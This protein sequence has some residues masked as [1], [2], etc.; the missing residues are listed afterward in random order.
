MLSLL[1][2]LN[3]PTIW[4]PIHI[5]M[6]NFLGKIEELNGK[7]WQKFSFFCHKCARTW[8]IIRFSPPKWHR[9]NYLIY[10][11][12]IVFFS[13]FRAPLFRQAEFFGKYNNLKSLNYLAKTRPTL[14]HR[15]ENFAGRN[16]PML[17][18]AAISVSFYP[19]ISQIAQIR[20]IPK[21]RMPREILILLNHV[22]LGTKRIHLGMGACS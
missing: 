9:V 2:S 4:I 15:L 6:D 22:H 21:Q 17:P 7:K 5:F 8:L 3:F 12:G 11:K 18:S 10:G 14:H 19:Q 1:K 13:F 16:N 20:K